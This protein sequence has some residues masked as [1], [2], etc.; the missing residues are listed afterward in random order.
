MPDFDPISSMSSNSGKQDQD[1]PSPEDMQDGKPKEEG[2]TL[3][4]EMAEEAGMGDASDGETWMVTMK[5]KR[6]GDKWMPLEAMNAKMAG[7][8]KA[9]ESD[10]DDDKKPM[11]G[12]RSPTDMGLSNKDGEPSIV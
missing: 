4:D 2:F 12:V 7:P 3:P 5:L 10:E 9:E 11:P 6:M 8:E 1:S